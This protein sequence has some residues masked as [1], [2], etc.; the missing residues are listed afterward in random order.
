MPGKLPHIG[1]TDY[2]R[3]KLFVI[4][5]SNYIP[6]IFNGFPSEKPSTGGGDG[7]GQ[8]PERLVS[9]PCCEIW[10]QMTP[11]SVN[12]PLSLFWN[13]SRTVKVGSD[14]PQQKIFE[15]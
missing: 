3:P 1:K 6:V 8:G 10:R 13:F 2:C 15:I 5:A 7:Q 4:E 9:S 11:K 14:V 12:C